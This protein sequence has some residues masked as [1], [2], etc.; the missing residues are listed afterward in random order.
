LYDTSNSGLPGTWVSEIAIE[1]NGTVWIGTRGDGIVAFDG[2]DWIAYDSSNS[3]LPHDDIY[4]LEIDSNNL[5]WIGTQAVLVTFDGTNWNQITPY[6]TPAI[7]IS[8]SGQKWIGAADGLTFIDGSDTTLFPVFAEVS[9]LSM[10]I[11][12]SLN[13][14]IGAYYFLI[15][16]NQDNW[17]LYDAENSGL[18]FPVHPLSIQP[19]HT[20][21]L[22][23]CY[24]WQIE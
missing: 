9:F 16:F 14:W 12:D 3:G 10:A 15:Y 1:E 2:E 19:R 18:A 7:A 11:G 21:C 6:Y 20:C 8:P 5:K 23:H 17:V 22:N 13:A 24:Y 4:S